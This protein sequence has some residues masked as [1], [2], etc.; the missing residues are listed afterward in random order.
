MNAVFCTKCSTW[1]ELFAPC[2]CPRP[3]PA[4]A[5]TPSN[6]SSV[7][8]VAAALASDRMRRT[9]APMGVTESEMHEARAVVASEVE[10]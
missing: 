9:G 3:R 2:A 1:R 6:F 7:V 4:P 5:S 8:T 10:A